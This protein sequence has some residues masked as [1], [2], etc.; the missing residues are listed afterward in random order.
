[1][2]KLKI[3]IY[4]HPTLRM[5]CEPVTEFNDEL[6]ELAE[7]MHV[8]MHE[9]DGVGLAASQVGR[10]IRML[11]VGVPK[12]EDSEE[13]LSLSI[14][15]P[16][17]LESKGSWEHEEGCLS[18]PDIRDKVTRPEWIKVR[19]QDLTGK[20]FILETGGLLA[21]VIQHE[22]D[23]LNGVMFV[24]HLSPIKRALYNGRLKRMSRDQN[25]EEAA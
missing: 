15:N 22:L 23:H 25:D 4:G 12:S 13:L 5:R 3:L 11:V 2:E 17:I 6:K 21:R 1:V 14:V 16:E 19:Y 7:A 20:E 18:I 8:T 24:D 9:N 10:R